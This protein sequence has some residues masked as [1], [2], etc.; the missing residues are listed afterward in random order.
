MREP[1]LETLKKRVLLGDGGM[2][3][4]LQEAGLKTGQCGELWN[5]EH[6]DWVQEIQKRYADAGSDLILTNT[7]GASRM[8]LARHKLEHRTEEINEAGARIAREVMGEDRWVVGDIGPYGGMLEPYGDDEAADVRESFLVQARGL[9]KGDV[10]A[11]IVETMTALEELT[12][13]IEAARQAIEEAGQIG[14]VAVIGS[15][16]FDHAV[17]G[18]PKTMMGVDP[19]RAAETMQDLGVDVIA[20]NCG[21]NL[22]IKDYLQVVQIYK[23]RAPN[24]PVM[25]QPNAGQPEMQGTRIV[26]HETPDMMAMGVHPL[27]EAGTRIIGGCCGTTPEHIRY[28]RQEVDRFNAQ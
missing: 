12:P 1:L 3:T 4:Q 7:F 14:K 19:E 22:D 20:E 6:P 2:G 15:M 16:A 23:K 10:D 25:A 9:V 21:S 18:P 13:G 5:V 28:F 11:L 17:S 8:A 26:Y 27:L 24:V